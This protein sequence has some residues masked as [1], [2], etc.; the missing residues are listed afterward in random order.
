MRAALFLALLLP[1]AA[2]D[3]GDADALIGTW[4]LEALTEAVRVT[5]QTAQALPDVSATPTASVTAT[6]ALSADLDV[7]TDL[8]A[9]DGFAQLLVA[10]ASRETAATVIELAVAQIPSNAQANLVDDATGGSFFGFFGDATVLEQDGGRFTIPSLTLNGDGQVTVSGTVVYPEIALAPDQ[11]TEVQPYEE[12]LEGVL[13]LTFAADGTFAAQATGPGGTASATGTWDR[14]DAERVRLTAT[15]GDAIESGVF[16][17][18]VDGTSLVL[19]GEDL[20]APCSRACIRRVETEVF[21]EPGS[22]SAA[23]FV[24]TFRFRAG[25]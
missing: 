19:K 24:S 14:L 15:E 5:S 6:G 20:D 4:R 7:V 11:P 23:S 2:C 3:G 17:A 10:T 18:S 9:S 1:L 12:E 8:T 13:T 21:A 22:L 25:S 16:E